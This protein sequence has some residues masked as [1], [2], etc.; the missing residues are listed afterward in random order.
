M[1]M[2]IRADNGEVVVLY[3]NE[4]KARVFTEEESQIGSLF[5]NERMAEEYEENTPTIEE[6]R[7][8]KLRDD[9]LNDM[10]EADEEF[11]GHR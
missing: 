4:T 9:H 1:A 10:M 7:E 8:E 6:L 11:G 3:A 2:L 5:F